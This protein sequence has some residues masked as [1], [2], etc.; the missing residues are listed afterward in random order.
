MAFSMKSLF[1]CSL[2]NFEE[3]VGDGTERF[4]VNDYWND[5]V[6]R[7][8]AKVKIPSG[9]RLPEKK[10]RPAIARSARNADIPRVINHA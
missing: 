6:R 1:L 5:I 7:C 3:R 2:A 4:L 9:L 10:M 8:A